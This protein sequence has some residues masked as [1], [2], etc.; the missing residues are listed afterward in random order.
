M[1]N[2]ILKNQ[3]P[4]SFRVI[5]SLWLLR[6][7]REASIL[8]HIRERPKVE[9]IHSVTLGM[10]RKPPNLK[11]KL[12]TSLVPG[13]GLLRRKSYLCLLLFP[14]SHWPR[15]YPWPEV[16]QQEW[17]EGWEGRLLERRGR[18]P[19]SPTVHGLVSV[20][21]ALCPRVTSGPVTSVLCLQS[22]SGVT[23]R[24]QEQEVLRLAL[25]FLGKEHRIFFLE[26]RTFIST[27]LH[28]QNSYFVF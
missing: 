6:E 17:E 19:T 4:C 2:C 26:H 7:R 9:K 22:A 15:P 23:H 5:S 3:T 10:A 24:P 28:A 1:K 13:D 8:L 27:T 14:F 25:L 16:S 12:G 11:V 21:P 18:S 20:R